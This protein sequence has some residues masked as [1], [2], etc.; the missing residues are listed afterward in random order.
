MGSRAEQVRGWVPMSE[1]AYDRLRERRRAA[2]VALAVA[3]AGVVLLLFSTRSD[4]PVYAALAIVGVGALLLFSTRSDIPVYAAL[5]IVGVG[6]VGW[7]AGAI[8]VAR[9]SVSVDLD[10]SRRWV[11]LGGVHPGFA[12]AADEHE[13]QRVAFRR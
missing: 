10:G 7:A 11:M 1:D 12:A 3:L 2:R 8:G 5:A 13:R 4:I 6:A 9:A